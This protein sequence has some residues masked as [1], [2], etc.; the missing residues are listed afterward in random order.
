MNDKVYTIDTNNIIKFREI[1]S[2]NDIQIGDRVVVLDSNGIKSYIKSNLPPD[3][4]VNP[5]Q[6]A[7]LHLKYNSLFKRLVTL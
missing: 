6:S 3:S 4:K 5:I 1:M 7:R 2:D